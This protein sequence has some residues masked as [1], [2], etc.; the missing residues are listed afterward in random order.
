MPFGGDML[1]GDGSWQPVAASSDVPEGVM[2]PFEIGSVIGFLR[3]VDGR[4]EAVSGICT[5]QGCRLW[6]DQSEDGLRCPCHSTSFSRSGKLLA[7]QLPIT[8]KP[9]PQLQVRERN[10]AIELFAPAEPT[11]PT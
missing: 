11:K 1:P 5:H 9:L 10:D 7:H 8:P 2:H 6:F 3:R 4:P